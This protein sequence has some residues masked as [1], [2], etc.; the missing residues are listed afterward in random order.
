MPKLTHEQAMVIMKASLSP[1]VCLPKED[2]YGDKIIMKVITRES[3]AFNFEF[4]RMQFSDESRPRG[5][6]NNLRREFES[7][8]YL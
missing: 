3:A 2:D 6:L 1:L 5:I 7:K 4:S 8:G